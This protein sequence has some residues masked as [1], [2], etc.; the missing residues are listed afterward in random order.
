M[1]EKPRKTL[2]KI[3]GMG[4]GE[5]GTSVSRKGGGARIMADQKKERAWALVEDKGTWVV[6]IRAYDEEKKK[7]IHKSKSTGLKVKDGTK[8]LAK[9]LAPQIANEVLKAY[10]PQ[11][12]KGETPFEVY[13]NDWLDGKEMDTRENTAKS[14]RDYA[15]NHVL[16]ALGK[17][18]VKDIDWKTLQRLCK[19]WATDHAK[20][21]VKK[22]FI[23]IRGALDDAIRD[24]AITQNPVSLVKWPKE[25][26]SEV[27]K[28]LSREEAA[29]LLRIAETAEEPMR[30]A[31]TLALVYGL[32]RSEVCGLRWMDIDFKKNTMHIRHT[33]TQNGE[34]LLDDDHTKSRESNRILPL[35][36]STVPYL[37]QLRKAQ[38]KSGLPLDKVV[39]WPDGQIVRPDGITRGFQTLQK[40]NGL[41]PIRFHDL[42]HTAATLLADQGLPPKQLQKFLGHNDI[43]MTLGVYVHASQEAASETAAMMDAIIQNAGD[44]SENCSESAVIAF[45]E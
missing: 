36:S 9:K 8:M 10:A 14:Y 38:A 7:Y 20:S 35:V 28:A 2:D 22:Y 18:P 16:P 19:K 45:G 43:K 27:S 33:V 42:R 21:S 15:T 39:V 44:C 37:K 25:E 17:T 26:K 31:V 5:L 34:V 32:R 1:Q 30:A 29:E 41:N 12:V 24:G 13:V 40:R 23:V 3:P 4:Y 6:R 11:S